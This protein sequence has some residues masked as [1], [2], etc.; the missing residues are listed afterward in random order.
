MA[1][2]LSI[3]RRV[4]YALGNPGHQISDR[5]VVLIAVY[6]YLPPPGRG[7]ETRVPAQ[8]FFGFLTVY[9]LATLVGRLFDTAADPV[10]G[11]LSD[12]SRSRL[13]RRRWLMIL[14]VGPMVAVPVLLFFPPGSAGSLANGV[15]LAALLAL[16]FV[17]FTAYV[18]PYLALIPEVAWTQSERLRL[19]QLMN[20][21]SLPIMGLLTAWGVGLDLGRAA[22]LSAEDAVRWLVVGLSLLSLAFCIGPILAI[23]EARHTR[24]AHSE[25]GFREALIATLRNRPFLIYLLAQIFFLLGLNL[26]QPAA[27]YLATVV[28]GRS[29]GFTAWLL[30]ALG[31]GIG[32]G[33]ALQRALVTRMGPKGA[34]MVCVALMAASLPLLGWLEPDVPGGPRD[35]ANLVLCFAAFALF[36]IPAAG[37]MVM[38]HVLISQLI[39]ADE[40][41]TGAGRAA[42][43]FGVQGLLTKWVYGVSI[44]IFTWL[45]ARFGNSPDAPLGVILVGPVAAGFAAVA[46]GL[47]AF[48]PERRVLAAGLRTEPAAS[49]G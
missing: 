40:Q 42:M 3:R 5:I 45:L 14:G 2:P 22:G 41:R 30:I 8:V 25:L 19:S 37:V 31:S 46:F 33:F 32:L 38:P 23:D 16:Y 43:F 13:G 15:W 39:D 10:V 4:L 49:A 11:Y 24:V 28:L 44:W 47:Y 27:P 21:L 9:G 29:E 48:Y 12:R 26:V 34:M 6:F 17:A 1:E 20:G 35:R 36:G 18:A 7:L